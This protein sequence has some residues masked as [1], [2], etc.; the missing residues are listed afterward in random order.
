[1]EWGAQLSGEHAQ[2]AQGAAFCWGARQASLH[3]IETPAHCREMARWKGLTQSRA[4]AGL[5]QPNALRETGSRR[6]CPGPALSLRASVAHCEDI[7]S[8]QLGWEEQ[9]RP[10]FHLQE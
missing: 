2:R 9:V 5:F 1:M 8:A 7:P 4:P 6:M 10:R 3:K